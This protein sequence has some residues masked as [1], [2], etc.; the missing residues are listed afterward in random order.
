MNAILIAL[1][2]LAA[3]GTA[4]VLIR[5]IITMAQGK[6]ISGVQSN[7]YMASRVALQGLTILLVILLFALGGRGLSGG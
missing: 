2:V 7:K 4:Y 1:I 5:G 3:G 6:D